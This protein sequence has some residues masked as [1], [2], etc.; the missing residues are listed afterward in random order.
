MISGTAAHQAHRQTGIGLSSPA[1]HSADLKYQRNIPVFQK[2][3]NQMRTFIEQLDGRRTAL[4]GQQSGKIPDFLQ[5]LQAQT[6]YQFR[7]FK[8]KLRG[9]FPAFPGQGDNDLRQTSSV[10]PDPSGPTGPG[11]PSERPPTAIRLVPATFL[12]VSATIFSMEKS[13]CRTSSTLP[14]RN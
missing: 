4:P 14:R 13:N 12:A 5:P 9:R 7:A 1:A 2:I 8:K 11:R 3:I 10:L 6:I